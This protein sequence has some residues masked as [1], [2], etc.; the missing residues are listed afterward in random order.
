MPGC[1]TYIYETPHWIEIT[2]IGLLKWMSKDWYVYVPSPCTALAAGGSAGGLSL[3]GDWVTHA[4]TPSSLSLSLTQ[5]ALTQILPIPDLEI[6]KSLIHNK[7]T[8]NI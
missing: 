3:E 7:S 1:D 8:E 2:L 5:H 6:D 4:V